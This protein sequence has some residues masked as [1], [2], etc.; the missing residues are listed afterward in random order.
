MLFIYDIYVFLSGNASF[1]CEGEKPVY[2]EDNKKEKKGPGTGPSPF[3]DFLVGE[4]GF[5]PAAF[6]FGGHF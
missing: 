3:F 1:G 2:R 4:A 5:E 6:G